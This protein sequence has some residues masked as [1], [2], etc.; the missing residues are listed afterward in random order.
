MSFI[1]IVRNVI[2]VFNLQDLNLNLSEQLCSVHVDIDAV[3]VLF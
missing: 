2:K 1:Y 3:Y